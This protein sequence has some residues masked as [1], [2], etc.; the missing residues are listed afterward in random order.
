VVRKKELSEEEIA[1]FREAVGD[2][3]PVRDDSAD[4]KTARPAPR[5]RFRREDDEAVKRE[6]LAGDWE[7]LPETGEV[8]VFTRPGLRHDVL[9]RLRRG[10]I[11]VRDELDLH[12]MNWR[13]ARA[14][15]ADFL[16][17]CRQRGIHCVRIIHG[18]GLRSGNNG[19][20]IKTRLNSWLQKRE[21]ILAFCS[22]RPNDGGTGALYVLLNPD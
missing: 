3:R 19:P 15:V 10:R 16:A 12:G 18:K 13:D 9:R 8:L 1:L 20:V 22:A 11:P 5:A 21:D 14:C 6:S 17:E 2:V 7:E 4:R